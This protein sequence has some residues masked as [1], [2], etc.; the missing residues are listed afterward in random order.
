MNVLDAIVK[1][2][3]VNLVSEDGIML[4]QAVKTEYFLSS[5]FLSC[6][7][8]SMFTEKRL[9]GDLLES[10]GARNILRQMR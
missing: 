7:L 3:G 2:A 10:A 9:L 4:T 1:D 8:L 5:G 6:H